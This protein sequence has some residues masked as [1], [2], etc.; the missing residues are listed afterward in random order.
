MAPTHASAAAYRIFLSIGPSAAFIASALYFFSLT[1][2]WRPCWIKHTATIVLM[3]SA[4]AFVLDIPNA[5]LLFWSL[6]NSED[7]VDTD[8]HNRLL[9]S[10]VFLMGIHG[11]LSL[12]PFRKCTKV[13]SY[14]L[15]KEL[16]ARCLN[17]ENHVSNS[18]TLV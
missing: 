7:S 12:V 15:S 9:L 4:L 17:S 16:D 8:T 10:A 14:D 11:I 3:L 2:T 13:Q 6:N 5:I 1:K 18:D